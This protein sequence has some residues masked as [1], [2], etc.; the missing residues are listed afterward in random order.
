LAWSSGRWHA[1]RGNWLW[2]YSRRRPVCDF[3]NLASKGPIDVMVLV[4]DHFEPESAS[5]DAAAG[6]TV[7]SWCQD[8]EA[9]ARRHQDADGRPPQH[10]WFLRAEYPNLGC[11]HA[12]SQSVFHGFGEV[13][14]HLHHGHDTEDTFSAKLRAG[15]DWFNQMG[16]MLTAEPQPRQRF[17]YIAGNW[18]LDNGSGDDAASG[19][20]TEL[21]A[22]RKTGCYADF[23]FPALGSRAQPRKT[24]ALYYAVEDSRP[25]SYDT[26]V[27]C[28]VGRPPT[29]DL[30]IFQ[31]PVVVDWQ[32]GRFEGAALENFDPPTP[33]R[34]DLWLRA[35]IHVLGR[36]EW[37]FVKLHT[38]GLQSRKAFLSPQLD[39]LLASMEEQWNQ[40]PFRLHYVTARQAYNLVRA[41]EAGNAGD[42]N[43]YLDF[44][45]PPPANR[46]VACATP[47]HLLSA[48]DQRLAVESL[49]PGPVR[50][51]FSDRPLV[52]VEG[53]IE[54]LEAFCNGKQIERVEIEGQGPFRLETRP[55]LPALISKPSAGKR[56][57]FEAPALAEL[58]SSSC[59]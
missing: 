49:C 18:A 38:H 36:P 57:I 41:A 31:G 43:D 40:P 52:S 53:N 8:Y 35:H 19:C 39:G 13:E 32:R 5:G 2:H 45:I 27:D 7:A 37:I 16:A 28:A 29:G 26:G 4:V 48:T 50:F 58:G 15:L 47:W 23:T 33:H 24:N 34:L 54:R 10:T 21:T 44:E 6:Q 51:N 1:L 46:L 25:K 56:T 17:G 42:P 22:L 30:L 14:F 3:R 20:D 11:L 59:P 12:L 55:S 9:L